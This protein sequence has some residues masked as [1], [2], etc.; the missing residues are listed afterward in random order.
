MTQEQYNTIV[1][2]LKS[3]APALAEELIVA[4]NNVLAENTALKKQME[5]K[6]EKE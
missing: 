1:K 4:I 5:T 6:N 3:G 2:I